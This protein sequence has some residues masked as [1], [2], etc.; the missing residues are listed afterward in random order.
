MVCTGVSYF[1]FGNSFF[2]CI[3]DSILIITLRYF[4]VALVAL[5]VAVVTALCGRL[6]FICAY[7]VNVV[8]AFRMNACTPVLLAGLARGEQAATRSARS[9]QA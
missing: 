1:H 5:V 8:S 2:I 4:F 7:K 3:S 6:F 9:V